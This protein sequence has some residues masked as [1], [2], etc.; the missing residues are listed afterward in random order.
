MLTLQDCI[1][2]CG[3][4]EE[5]VDAIALHEHVPETAAAEIASYLVHLPNGFP[6]VRRVI[7]D[8]IEAARRAGDHAKLRRLRLTLR[9]FLAR[10]PDCGCASEEELAELLKRPGHV[11]RDAKA[12]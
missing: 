3:L 8:D 10:H 6:V 11:W 7:L 5:E 12:D 4:S 9:H 1:A 2:L